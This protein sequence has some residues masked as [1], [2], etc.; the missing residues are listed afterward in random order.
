LISATPEVFQYDTMD[1]FT[2]KGTSSNT[3]RYSTIQPH[4]VV[5][6][7]TASYTYDKN[8]SMK[9]GNGT[10]YTYDNE[11]RLYGI[12]RSGYSA[13]YYYGTGYER[14]NKAVTSGMMSRTTL[15]FVPEYEEEYTSTSLTST[16]VYY[17][18]NGQRVAQRTNT[19]LEY[20]HQD[21]LG[22]T[23]AIT[24]SAGNKK[25][26][27]SYRA[28]GTS[29]ANSLT[30]NYQ[31][32]GGETDQSGLYYFNARYYSP[33]TGR[34]IS[35]DPAV[36]MRMDVGLSIEEIANPYMYARNS[37]IRYTDITGLAVTVSYDVNGRHETDTTTTTSS[38]VSYSS[39]GRYEQKTTTTTS[40]TTSY[41]LKG[42]KEV[43]T[44]NQS[45]SVVSIYTNNFQTVNALHQ[46]QNISFGIGVKAALIFGIGVE[47]GAIFDSDK[48]FGL[49][50]TF[51]LGTGIQLGTA[52]NTSS[53]LRNIFA[54]ALGY[55]AGWSDG[56]VTG[57]GTTTTT[58]EGGAFVTGSWNLSD[59]NKNGAPNSW[60]KVGGGEIV[61][62]NGRVLGK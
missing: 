43:N 42:S 52:G 51:S 44:Q 59:L 60:G 6:T 30:T 46:A 9:T 1:R 41:D 23:I 14:V 2:A 39:S 24:D 11:A 49:Y 28:Y 19:T 15:Y 17:I 38:T 12:S 21:H 37:P 55:G 26:A 34:F 25:S 20:L 33:E 31:W 57:G 47:F 45:Y 53:I 54:A 8:G 3:Y 40:S 35:V 22:S 36:I 27:E 61:G 16:K 32:A 56:A 62:K 50:G 48:S 13:Q 10:T 4:A 29:T 18:V 58:A 5:G 7:S